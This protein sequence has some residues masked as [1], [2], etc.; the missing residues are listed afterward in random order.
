M[1]AS[2]H[3]GIRDAVA[4]AYAGLL[5]PA[6]IL[7]NRDHGMPEGVAAQIHVHRTQSVPESAPVMTGAPLDWVTDIRTLVKARKDGATSAEDVADDLAG[8]CFARVMAD[9]TLGG[10]CFQIESGPFV[11]DQDEQDTAVAVATWDIRVWHRTN[12]NTVT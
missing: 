10:L 11:W 7:A 12:G 2:K 8:Q 9:Q 4:A 6:R 5:D 3:L 1:A